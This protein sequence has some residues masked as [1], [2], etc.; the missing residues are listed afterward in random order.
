MRRQTLYIN[1]GLIQVRVYDGIM[2]Y[3]PCPWKLSHGV[4]E[5][6]QGKLKQQQVKGIH[7]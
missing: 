6:G 4:S 5:E 7:I 2:K 3:P 1:V